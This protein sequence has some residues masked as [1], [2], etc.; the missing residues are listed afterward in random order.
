MIGESRTEA[1]DALAFERIGI[2]L[3]AVLFDEHA[4]L[5]LGNIS[6]CPDLFRIF[7][8]DGFAA[9]AFDFDFAP[10]GKVGSE[11]VNGL[12]GE[13]ELFADRFVFAHD[14]AGFEIFFDD[15]TAR[16]IALHGGFPAGVVEVGIGESGDFEPRVIMFAV[17][18][19]IE[20]DRAFVE[21]P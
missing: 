19:R 10:A 14:F 17:A 13:N 15:Q 3:E 2:G 18:E 1:F 5:L 11:I 20:A 16:R 6:I 4:D 12:I 7:E 8:L 21:A 9:H